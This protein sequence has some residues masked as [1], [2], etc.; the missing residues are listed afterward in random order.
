PVEPDG[1]GVLTVLGN[2]VANHAVPIETHSRALNE[3]NVEV[4]LAGS[5]AVTNPL[6][7][8]LA[9]FDNTQFS[10]DANGFVS[11]TGGGLAI[12]S[13]GVQATSGT[14]TDPVV[15]TAAGLVEFEGGTV[16]A[17]TNPVRAVSTAANT[18]Q[19]QNQISQALAAT[20]AT[21]IGLCNFD[22]SAFAVDANGFVTFIGTTTD[23]H[24]TRSIVSAGGAAAGA[25]Y[26]TIASAIT[27]A[28][29]AGGVQTILT[30]HGTYT[31]GLTPPANINLVA[32]VGDHMTPTVTI[33]GKI[34]CSDA[35]SRTIS[36]IRLKTN[37]DFCLVVSGSV[38]TVVDLIE[39]FIQASNNTAISYTSSSSSSKINL[40]RC[41]GNLD[42]TGIA[43]LSL[44]GAG[45]TNIDYCRF[46]NTGNSITASTS[47][48]GSIQ[49][50]H[51]PFGNPLTTSGTARVGGVFSNFQFSS[52]NV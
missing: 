15:P 10:V 19:I 11:L 12:D 8:G 32:H 3:F 43:Y 46:G 52:L 17:G 27:A 48:A 45:E 42:T 38:A 24:D 34:T 14:G 9:H 30:H 16:A 39:C 44:S 35:G 41:G 4:Q 5:A 25:H 22:S 28:T 2:Y 31:A 33:V 7:S 51:S 36:G 37:S 20:D 13:I 18:V 23:P 47:S 6:L 40:T 26:T 1:S 49:F 29:S 50:R 21:K